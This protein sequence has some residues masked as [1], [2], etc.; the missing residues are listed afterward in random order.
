M[1]PFLQ[2]KELWNEKQIKIPKENYQKYVIANKLKYD[3]SKQI[4]FLLDR[5]SYEKDDNY[6]TSLECYVYELLLYNSD[7]N[8]LDIIK[9]QLINTAQ[10]LY[11]D[12]C[13]EYNFDLIAT[14]D[15]SLKLSYKI[16]DT[17]FS[18]EFPIVNS[19]IGWLEYDI[20][21]NLDYNELRDT[22]MNYM[23]DHLKEICDLLIR[24]CT[25][26]IYLNKV[27]NYPNFFDE[28]NQI[29]FNAFKY[30]C[31]QIQYNI[32]RFS[33]VYKSEFEQYVL[34]NKIN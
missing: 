28:M 10:K 13:Y 6:M 23:I 30:E 14:I 17:P 19:A 9:T 7:I 8:L 3:Y 21:P 24:N 4:D 33:L 29:I 18:I 31:Y 11:P 22:I 16:D 26:K 34:K 2:L 5:Y 1:I 20:D 25:L 12:T 32:E 27:L 15:D